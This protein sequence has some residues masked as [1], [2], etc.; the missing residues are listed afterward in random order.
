MILHRPYFP[1]YGP[2]GQEV[3]N[4]LP[5]SERQRWRARVKY[6]ARVAFWQLVIGVPILAAVLVALFVYAAACGGR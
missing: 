2:V 4:S 3:W 1:F 5:E 6:Q